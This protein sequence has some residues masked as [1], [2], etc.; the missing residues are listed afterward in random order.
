MG[1]VSAPGPSVT[2][3]SVAGVDGLADENRTGEP[4]VGEAIVG[5][6]IVGEA[7]LVS[8]FS[9]QAS[10]QALNVFFRFV[11][12]LRNVVSSTLPIARPCF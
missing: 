5:G 4:I 7:I 6:A 2:E 10:A 11:V 8:G 3:L 9:A 1:E 12:C